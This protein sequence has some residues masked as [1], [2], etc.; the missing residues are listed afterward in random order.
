ML[1][2]W[3]QLLHFWYVNA[4]PKCT[5]PYKIIWSRYCH[6]LLTIIGSN[7]LLASQLDRACQSMTYLVLFVPYL[8]LKSTN[9]QMPNIE[10]VSR[11]VT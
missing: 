3:Q 7:E 1:K 8:V 2:K 6:N 5:E 11:T 4:Q 9:T 10:W